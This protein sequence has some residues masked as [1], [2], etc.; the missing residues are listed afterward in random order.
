[1]TG[2]RCRFRRNALHQTAIAANGV[3]VVV[4]DVETGLVV[5]AREPPL[6]NRHPD[7]GSDALPKWACRCLDARYPMVLRVAGR[8]AVELA[9]APD[10]V[11]R[12]RWLTQPF[13]L[14]VHST[15][16]A[17]MVRRPEQH[18]SMAVR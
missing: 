5:A 7:A 13:I 6:R 8:L 2:Q 11:K 15:R 16:A 1:M 3:D 9:E 18:R 17:E 12:H 14:G 4:E 10:V